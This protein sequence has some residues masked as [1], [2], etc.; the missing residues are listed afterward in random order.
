M[1]FSEA[2][3][4]Q[5]IADFMW[6]MVRIGAMMMAAPIFSVRQVP[7]RFRLL[8]TII[9]TIV[10]QPLI[11]SAPVVKLFS[12]DFFMI[13]LHQVGIGVMIGFV[14]QLA[15]AA[16]IFSGQ[17]M[18]YSMGLGFASMMDPT[19]GVQVPVV[20][21]YW[22]ILAMLGFVIT[23]GHL[24]LISNLVES[25]TILPIATEGLSRNSLWELLRWSSRVFSAGLVMAMPIV[26]ALLLLNI[27]LG[28]ISRAAPQLN[29]FA[30]GFP[31]SITTG[32][33]LVWVTMPHVLTSFGQLVTEAF[34]LGLYLLTVR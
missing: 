30:I 3:M 18:A 5:Y 10:V 21:Q 16:L 17:V 7:M 4:S 15:F 32:F 25:F 14:M 6:P 22:L 9:I 23:N 13:M 28:V 29:I 1:Q 24:V 26:I 8:L 33:L 12:P 31:I 34:D 20:S 27:G 11:P 2:I 19:N